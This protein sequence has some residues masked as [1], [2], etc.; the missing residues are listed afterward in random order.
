MF[1]PYDT[2]ISLWFSSE[3]IYGWE[4][5]PNPPVVG[6]EPSADGGTLTLPDAEGN[7]PGAA[8]PLGLPAMRLVFK[9]LRWNTYPVYSMRENL[10]WNEASQSLRQFDEESRDEAQREAR[11]LPV[12]TPTPAPQAGGTEPKSDL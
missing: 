2:S 9:G 1:L 8:T 10:A 6:C 12:K 11:R 3:A 7:T 5:V 4:P